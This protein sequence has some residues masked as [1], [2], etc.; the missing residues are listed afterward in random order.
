MRSKG[1]A[2]QGQGNKLC[3][4]RALSLRIPLFKRFRQRFKKGYS[5][6]GCGQG[7]PMADES[8]VTG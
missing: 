3:L 4:E 2:G 1:R 5:Q 8:D 6:A 7:E